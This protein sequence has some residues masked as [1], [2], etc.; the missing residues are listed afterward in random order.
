MPCHHALAGALRAYIDAA[1]IA[2]DRKGFL[3]R[4][5][6]GHRGIELSEEPMGQPDAWRRLAFSRRSAIT[7]FALQGSRHIFP[8]AA[9]WSTLRRWQ[10]TKVRERRSSTTGRRNG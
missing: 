2:E 10:H 1:G 8:T 9:R 7:P 5:S 6:R 3:F 4:T